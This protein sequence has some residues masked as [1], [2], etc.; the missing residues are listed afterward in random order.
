[1]IPDGVYFEVMRSDIDGLRSGG[2]D[3]EAFLFGV[4]YQVKPTRVVQEEKTAFRIDTDRLVD[5]IHH[6]ADEVVESQAHAALSHA[7]DT[8]TVVVDNNR[9]EW[10]LGGGSAAA[11]VGI[12][13]VLRRF[14]LLPGAGKGDDDG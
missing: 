13:L 7:K 12:L 14:G 2:L 6:A 1:M 11:L 5:S 4:R 10:A 9:A 8:A 3:G